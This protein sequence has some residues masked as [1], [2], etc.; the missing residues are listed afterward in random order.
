MDNQQKQYRSE[1][2]TLILAA[3][4]GIIGVCG[5]GHIYV[6]LLAR[7]F[8]ILFGSLAI[9]ILGMVAAIALMLFPGFVFVP[10]AAYLGFY[11]WSVFDARRIVRL[12]NAELAGNRDA[13]E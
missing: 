5:I 1:G 13:A 9:G 7:G 2:T 8:V 3:V 6:G 4:L 11:V 10:L 12:H